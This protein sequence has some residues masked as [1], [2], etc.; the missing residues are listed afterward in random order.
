MFPRYEISAPVASVFVA[1]ALLPLPSHAEVVFDGSVG[2][3]G[4]L[5]GDM[6]VSEEFGARVGANLFH[7]FL[8]LNVNPGESLTFTSDFAGMTSNVISRVTGANGSLI[9]GPVMSAIPGASVWLINPNGLVFGPGAFIDVQ[10]GF[11]AS[12][13]DYLLLE[14][15]GRFGADVALPENTVLTMANPTTFGFLGGA[16]APISVDGAG[17]FVPY[18]EDL[19]L[20]GGDV[21]IDY[22]FLGAEGGSLGI[23]G[24]GG[25]GDVSRGAGGYTGADS[26][27][28]VSLTG[29]VATTSGDGGGAI[30]IRGGQF[31]MDQSNVE[32]WSYG[33]ENG[34]GV[35]VDADEVTLTGSSRLAGGTD[36]AGRGSNINV[37]AAGS[38]L[39]R[40]G[41]TIDNRVFGS[42]DGGSITVT[43]GESITVDGYNEWGDGSFIAGSTW[44]SGN[45]SA[46]LL[47]A[48]EITVSNGAF[49][50]NSS[51]GE[52]NAGPITLNA[53]E[54]VNLVG[55]DANGFSGGIFAN[56]ASLGNS[57]DVTINTRD[58]NQL[59]AAYV[60]ILTYGPAAGGDLL[61][62][63]S[64]DVTIAGTG[65]YNDPSWITTGSRG[66]GP[67]GSI[68]INAA[69]MYVRDGADLGTYAPGAS[70]AGPITLTIDGLLEVSG[71][72]QD[73]FGGRYQT[74]IDATSR[75]GSGGNVTVRADEMRL[76]DGGI[77]VTTTFGYGN[78]GS[79][80]IEVSSFTAS[81]STTGLTNPDGSPFIWLSGV[82][83]ISEFED[84]GY[85]GDITIRADDIT[86]GRG[87][88][89]HS[90]S[91]SRASGS[92]VLDAGRS[93]RV[94]GEGLPADDG[95]L[96]WADIDAYSEF[97]FE[98][99]GIG[100]SITMSAPVID[101]L[102]GSWVST[103]ANYNNGQAGTIDIAASER[104]T[105]AGDE[106]WNA[107]INSEGAFGAIPGNINLT[108]PDIVFSHAYVL[109]D[110]S[111]SSASAGAINIT[112]ENSITV[113]NHTSIDALTNYGGNGGEI[114]LS[115]PQVTVR[116]FA[117][118]VTDTYGYADMAGSI[119][120][121]ATDLTIANGGLID[122][123]ACFCAFG[124]A[125]SIYINVDTLNIT[126]T[127]DI[128]VPTGIRSYTLGSG[129]SGSI[130]IVANQV[131]MYDN[132]QIQAYSLSS[133]QD[134][135]DRDEPDREPGDAGSISIEA[136]E[137]WMYRSFIETSAL[138]A[139]GGNI[140][141]NIG[142]IV[143]AADSSITAEANGVDAQS[144]GG[145]IIIASPQFVI[146][147]SSNIVASANAG[148][149][150]NILISTE[151]IIAGPSST[152]D[153]SSQLG[154]DGEVV[155]DS[156]NR[157]AASVTPLDAP[158]LDVSTFTQD[159]CEVSVDRDRSSFTVPGSGGVMA[160]PGDYQASPVA[161]LNLARAK[162]S[163]VANVEPAVC[164]E[165]TP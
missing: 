33:V 117:G 93:I 64:G 163:H 47:E 50:W 106:E 136:N 37:S 165:P 77:I 18:G 29:S 107:V 15:G 91:R 103:F 65:L 143:Y 160:A 31:V 73:S 134:F 92:I 90:Y 20:V 85:G 97:A 108:A 138:E 82:W 104:L 122:A 130:E 84:G 75:N 57:S 44:G 89:L 157:L 133:K 115:A 12:T 148:N 8:E 102:S 99:D 68:T 128:D 61:I 79:V 135:I 156:P 80:D 120:V 78:A 131:F 41:S 124:G 69:N 142:E 111:F 42:G 38:V 40:E 25:A 58:Y 114:R 48:P 21:T 139:A 88:G 152:I 2:P 71:Q 1:S 43:A 16:P 109:S 39:L 10:G 81:G 55:T 3:T 46:M 6:I 125:G 24:V 56:S 54:S 94:G 63:A 86:I 161:A 153:A 23:A 30:F 67:S 155:V 123:N 52:G 60:A 83:A 17:L 22:G 147:D 4:E 140:E 121:D 100:G 116:N 45:G 51:R 145:N 146:L 144:N 150:G 95:W 74:M 28:T 7:S 9:D 87:G 149:G 98:P 36:Y 101:L 19:E 66:T 164:A 11:H 53:A 141:L 76:I 32:S 59:D 27:A 137:L 26:W 105:I 5:F 154:V 110:V 129:S 14:D 162:E 113:E 132:A 72:A 13:A 159:P 49:L 34:A 158:V 62:N 126:G 119:F 35:Y 112:A 118:I 96:Q 70:D 151:A 127:S